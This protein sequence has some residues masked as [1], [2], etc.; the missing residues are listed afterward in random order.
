[1]KKIPLLSNRP[2]LITAQNRIEKLANLCQDRLNF[3]AIHKGY[4]RNNEV[5]LEREEVHRNRNHE[6]ENTSSDQSYSSRRSYREKEREAELKAQGEVSKNLRNNRELAKQVKEKIA[7]TS[8]GRY[9]IVIGLSVPPLRRLHLRPAG[10]EVHQAKLQR[11]AQDHQAIKQI[12]SREVRL[13]AFENCQSREAVR[14]AQIEQYESK[15]LVSSSDDIAV[16]LL[17]IGENSREAQKRQPSAKA[18]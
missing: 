1:M 7:T 4:V 13:S 16:P 11:D 10:G 8:C 2:R 3:R 6:M 18:G 5:G 9:D 12:L 15:I 17:E 14:K